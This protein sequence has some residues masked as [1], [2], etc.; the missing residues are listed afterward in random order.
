VKQRPVNIPDAVRINRYLSMSGISSRRGAEELILS[1]KVKVNG[2]VVSDLSTRVH[3]Q[4]D[5]VSVNGQ[6]IAPD[7]E[8]VYFVLNKPKDTITTLKDEKGRATVME[9]VST[10]HRVYPIGRLDRHT[11]GVLLL[12][13]DGEFAHKLMHP[14]QQIPKSY[15]VTLDKSLLPEHAQLLARGIRL[16][17]GLTAPAE[18]V[19]IPQGKG[20][21]VGI[22]IHEGRNRQVRRMFEQFGY[23]VKKLDRVAYGPILKTGLSRGEMRSLTR[24]ELRQLK[25]LAGISDELLPQFA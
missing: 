24:A 5:K 2:R 3:L 9:L 6:R 18:L 11:T 15:H 10:R 23:E 25:S 19:R 20:R 8:Y 16:E 7:Q 14:R 17:D 12:T 4:R 13:N 22:T 1:G 21:E